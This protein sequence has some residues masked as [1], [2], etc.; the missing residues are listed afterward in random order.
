M[1]IIKPYQT[2]VSLFCRD[3]RAWH[4]PSLKAARKELGLRWISNNVAEHFRTYRQTVWRDADGM[5]LYYGGTTS[6]KGACYPERFYDERDYIM[7]DDNGKP[8]TYHTFYSTLPYEQRNGRKYVAKYRMWNAKH[9]EWTGTGPV[10]GISRRRNGSR[11]GR[12]ISYMNAM[13]VAET[14]G[15]EGEVAVRPSR[16]KSLQA[17]RWDT[18]LRASRQDRSWKNFRKTQWK[19]STQ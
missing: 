10:P 8:V 11:R 3:G 17:D 15:E 1:H 18:Y 9:R 6:E 14:F 12:D 19:D 5:R 13:R 2:A 16:G 7:R 4:F